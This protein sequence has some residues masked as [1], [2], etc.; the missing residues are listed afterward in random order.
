MAKITTH[1]NNTIGLKPET[2]LAVY[3][4]VYVLSPLHPQPPIQHIFMM[5]AV[6]SDF[7]SCH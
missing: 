5:L 6:S 4:N 2:T 1:Q 7:S 3:F